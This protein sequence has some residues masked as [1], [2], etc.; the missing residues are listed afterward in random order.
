MNKKAASIIVFA[1]ALSLVLG[2]M[3]SGCG[4][5]SA[6]PEIKS[7]NPTSG[8]PGSEVAITG[9]SFGSTQGTGVVFFDSEEA[10]VASWSDISITVKVPADL[11][12]EKYGVKVETED[13]ASN[14]VE[15]EVT[16]EDANAPKIDSLS[17]ES[18]GPGTE[19]KV[20]GSKFGVTQG[21]GKVLFGPGTAEVVSWSDTSITFKVPSD[22]SPNTYGVTIE[23]AEGKSGEAIF[24]V[25]G[26]D[27]S[28]QKA[29]VIAYLQAQGQ[30][31][32]GS[33]NWTISLV[34]KSAQDPN[35]EVVKVTVP[36]GT[37]FE[38]VL[39]FN[40]MLGD[41]EALKTGEPP[42]TGVEFKGEPVPSD[43][44]NV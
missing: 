11:T 28:A 27:L 40:N 9:G 19:V 7:L 16:Q 24:T 43:L 38:A 10:D 3:F 25:G 39:V 2:L 1:A 8:P 21:G 37:S 23:T 30:S 15:F 14:S 35:W 17:P 13:G 36:G 6:R 29:A 41:W 18:G 26:E 44:E 12:A 5:A 20:S 22:A 32:A 4:K 42:W 34:K 31:T 33:E